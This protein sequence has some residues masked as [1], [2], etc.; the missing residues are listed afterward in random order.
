MSRLATTLSVTDSHLRSKC[1]PPHPSF[2]ARLAERRNMDIV[3]PDKHNRRQVEFEG[4]P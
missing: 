2:A 3:G 1:A 4:N